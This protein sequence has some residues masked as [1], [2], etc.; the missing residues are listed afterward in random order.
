MGISMRI[1]LI[2]IICLSPLACSS[3]SD[4]LGPLTISAQNAEMVAGQSAGAGDML[5]GMSGLVDNM[6]ELLDN[7]SAQV[8]FCDSGNVDLNIT[9]VA[10]VDQLSTG[11]MAEIDFRGCVIDLGDGLTMTLDG[12][13]KIEAILVSGDA[14]G[15]HDV[16]MKAD[17][18]NLSVMLGGA[19]VSIDGGF[20]LESSSPDGV[21]VTQVIRGDYFRAFASGG[22][23]V[24]SGTIRDFRYE[25]TFDNSTGAY[26]L[27]ASATVSGSQ[28]GG[29]VTYTTT[30]PFTGTDPDDPDAGEIVYTG[31][32]GATVTVIALDNVNVEIHVDFDA[33]QST[34]LTINTTW[35]ALNNS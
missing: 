31:A 30:T 12:M 2:A 25:R 5:E 11:D 8:V 10:P 34:D 19:S 32:K 16:Q 3:G 6:A 14:S 24:Y 7:P 33:D 17:F 26:S 35:D 23:Q 27:S 1:A 4:P 21:T 29:I 13:L 20:D 18:T 28:L 15:P 22:G 9:D